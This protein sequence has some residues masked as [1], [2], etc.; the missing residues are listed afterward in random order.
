MTEAKDGG[1]AFPLTIVKTSAAN[2]APVESDVY[3][4]MSL[5]DWFAG[6]AIPG[7]IQQ[8]AG[9]IPYKP[10]GTVPEEYFAAKAFAVADAMIAARAEATP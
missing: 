10:E 7:I 3:S 9:D 6:Q 5:R 8:C 4:G 1:P 2:G